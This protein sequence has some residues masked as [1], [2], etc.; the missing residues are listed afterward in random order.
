MILMHTS[1]IP[2]WCD[3]NHS[4]VETDG[5]DYGLTEEPTLTTLTFTANTVSWVEDGKT[6]TESYEVIGEGVLRV[7]D[8][9][10]NSVTYINVFRVNNYGNLESGD[11]KLTFYDVEE[12]ESFDQDEYEQFRYGWHNYSPDSVGIVFANKETAL[13]STAYTSYLLSWA[14]SSFNPDFQQT[15]EQSN[16]TEITPGPELEAETILLN[17]PTLL[18]KT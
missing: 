10:D 9:E 5:S 14:N 3:Y 18:L 8:S 12:G 15:A 2:G 11:F 16:P 17:T 13:G 4:D 1:I 7:T 6:V